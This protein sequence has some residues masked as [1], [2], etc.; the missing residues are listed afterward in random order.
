MRYVYALSGT[1]GLAVCGP[2]TATLLVGRTGIAPSLRWAGMAGAVWLLSAGTAWALTA[3]KPVFQRLTPLAPVGAMAP[4][5][6]AAYASDV[7][8]HRLNAVAG[9]VAWAELGLLL[10]GAVGTFPRIGRWLSAQSKPPGR[11]E[12]SGGAKS[13]ALVASV[14]GVAAMLLVNDAVLGPLGAHRL[15]LSGDGALVAFSAVIV[16]FLGLAGRAS[17]V[18]GLIALVGLVAVLAAWFGVA[19]EPIAARIPYA[20]ALG[21]LAL[22]LDAGLWATLSRRAARLC[23]ALMVIGAVL[24]FTDPQR[25]GLGA[26]EV[27]AFAPAAVVRLPLL[28]AGM[29]IAAT[30]LVAVATGAYASRR[31]ATGGMRDA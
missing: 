30:A 22:A 29:L 12:E 16:A 17:R 28:G 2:L 4:I 11:A 5:L 9:Q 21:A 6:A 10:A 31:A 20:V 15:V 13:P 25:L 24:A 19:P 26:R 14:G 7:D 27:V 8:Y 1:L 3:G 18:R 23:G